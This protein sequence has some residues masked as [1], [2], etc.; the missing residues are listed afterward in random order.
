[1]QNLA[2][3]VSQDVHQS[4]EGRNSNAIVLQVAPT[5]LRLGSIEYF[6]NQDKI[7]EANKVISFVQEH[8]YPDVSIAGIYNS[9]CREDDDDDEEDDDEFCYRKGVDSLIT[10]MGKSFFSNVHEL[11]FKAFVMGI[12]SSGTFGVDGTMLEFQ[13]ASEYF[14]KANILLTIIAPRV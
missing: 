2:L 7:I 14:D 6:V 11:G 12:V 4:K 1:M 3:I 8:F 13:L 5:F 10:E 9:N